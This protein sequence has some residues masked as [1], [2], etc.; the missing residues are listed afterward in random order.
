MGN[1]ESIEQEPIYSDILSIDN[2]EVINTDMH[3]IHSMSGGPILDIN[4]KEVLGILSHEPDAPFASEKFKGVML[5][6]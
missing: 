4:G 2:L 6:Y 5:N 1:F 3:F